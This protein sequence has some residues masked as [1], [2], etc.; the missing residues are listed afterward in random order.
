VNKTLFALTVFT[1]VLLIVAAG[2]GGYHYRGRFCMT[3]QQIADY[4]RDND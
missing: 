1:V 4:L 3:D 2:L